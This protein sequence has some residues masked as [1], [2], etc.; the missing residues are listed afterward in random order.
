[1]P[2]EF[3]NVI[4]TLSI[5][6]V[7]P[8]STLPGDGEGEDGD[9]LA[10]DPGCG[11]G[12]AIGTG[13]PAVAVASIPTLPRGIVVQTRQP[14]GLIVIDDVWS[15]VQRVVA[16]DDGTTQD[17]GFDLFHRD[18]GA[19]IACASCHP[20]GAEDGNVWRFSD[21]G[22]RRTQSLQADLGATAPFHWDG[23]LAGVDSIMSRVFVDRMGGVHQ[24]PGRLAALRD[25]LFSQEAPAPMRG[26][27][28]PAVERGKLL[29]EST[30]CTDCHSGEHL[31][32]NR[33]ANVGTGAALQVPS[34]VGIGYRAPFMHTGCAKT[35]ADRFNPS[36]GG[37][38]SH[39]RVRGL[40][41]EDLT[42]MVAYLESL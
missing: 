4:S 24:S 22:E 21:T 41:G 27:E 2:D 10:A 35:L 42:D 29:F 36:C 26:A 32:N 33:T 7:P 38:E 18:S 39:G 37:G 17:T 3:G 23:T 11:F 16:F 19:G 40:V 30:G 8:P 15:N 20:E 9:S 25:W 13:A 1:V 28:D 14:S 34:L 5:I 31:T 12:S 6:D